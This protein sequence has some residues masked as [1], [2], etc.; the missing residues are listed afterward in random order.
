M[1]WARNH[2]DPN[3]SEL[4]RAA[5]R[6][7]YTHEVSD[8]QSLTPAQATKLMEQLAAI[9]FGDDADARAAADAEAEKGGAHGTLTKPR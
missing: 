7:Q 6:I 3:E 2:S 8:I 5:R 1:Q 4:Q 9:A